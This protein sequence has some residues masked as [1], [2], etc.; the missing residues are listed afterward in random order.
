MCDHV[1]VPVI[2]CG[3]NV[4]QLCALHA[5]LSGSGEIRQELARCWCGWSADGYNGRG[6]LAEMGETLSW[7]ES[8]Y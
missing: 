5:H 4:C 6:E 2:N 7:D 3:A 1:F 8:D